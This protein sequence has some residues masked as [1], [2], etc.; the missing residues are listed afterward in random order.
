VN[1]IT[2]LDTSICSSNIG[3]SII[4]DAIKNE[5]LLFLKYPSPKKSIPLLVIQNPPTAILFTIK[6]KL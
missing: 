5:L 2:L 1:K 4:M 6:P 3:D